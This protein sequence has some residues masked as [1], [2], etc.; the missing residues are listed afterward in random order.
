MPSTLLLVHPI[1]V[2]SIKSC[3]EVCLK[4][5]L[6]ICSLPVGCHCAESEF[7]SLPWSAW[8][9]QHQSRIS[10]SHQHHFWGTVSNRLSSERQ[11]Q[12]RVDLQLLYLDRE[13]FLASDGSLTTSKTLKR[14]LTNFDRRDYVMWC[15]NSTLNVSSKF[16]HLCAMCAVQHLWE[17]HAWNPPRPPHLHF[18]LVE[19]G[20]ETYALQ[21]N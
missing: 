9:K 19:D 7:F 6:T 11:K 10:E 14:L 20:F 1:F 4:S 21:T 16:R 18:H 3:Y 12:G 2:Q 15:E 8:R 13:T 17:H 5:Q